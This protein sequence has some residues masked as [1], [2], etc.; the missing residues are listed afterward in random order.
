M[1]RKLRLEYPGAIYHVI[2]RGNYRQAIFADERTRSAFES[3]LFEACEKAAWVLHAFVLMRNHFHLGLETPEANLVAGIHWLECTFATRFNRFRRE[4]GHLFQG[5]Y[6]AILCEDGKPLGEV[7]DYIHLNPVRAGVVA[8]PQLPEYRFSSYWYLHNPARRPTFMRTQ[9]ALDRA[10][11]IADEP[12]GWVEYAGRL[13]LQEEAVV[14]TPGERRRQW[15][16]LCGTWA[17]GSDLFKATLIREHAIEA[18]SRAW[19]TSGAEE[20]RILKCQEMLRRGLEA[21]GRSYEDIKVAR[22]TAPWKLALAAWMKTHT[23]VPN[24]WLAQNLQMGATSA[25]GRN[26]ADYRR[27]IQEGDPNWKTLMSLRLT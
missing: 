1:P 18:S 16:R 14:R 6:K 10:G 26:V 8:V 20:I 5:R 24:Q 12:T 11:G 3:C 25:V 27:Q 23:L 21:L 2:N 15:K 17:I 4:N 13:E 9:T 19:R 22:K 7:C